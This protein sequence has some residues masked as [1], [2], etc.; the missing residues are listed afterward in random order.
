MV[1]EF[2]VVIASHRKLGDI[3]LP[4]NIERKKGQ[5]FFQ[6]IS[7]IT[8][9]DTKN[10]TFTEQQLNIIKTANEYSE[11]NIFKLFS[12]KKNLKDFFDTLDEA[13][14]T[15]QIRPY[16]EKR[17]C[18][19]I[20]FLLQSDIPVY[21]K[22]KNYQVV[23]EDERVELMT[24]PAQPVFNFVKSATEFLY[25]LSIR[26]NGKDIKLNKFP[27]T[28]I[29]QIP[30]SIIVNKKL[31]KVEN[32]DSK[33]LLPFF[34]K[35]HIT[36]PKAREKDYIETFVKN[37]VLNYPVKAVGIR[38]DEI[39]PQKTAIL[40]LEPDLSNNPVFGLKFKYGEHNFPYESTQHSAV[41]ITEEDT[42]C[43][44]TKVNRD[45]EWENSNIET[46]KQFNIT[47]KTGSSFNLTSLAPENET[48]EKWHEMVNWL[49]NNKERL[50]E[51]GF[52]VIKT[53]SDKEFYTGKIGLDFTVSTE[54]DWFDVHATVRIGEF[55]F[56]FIK[57][58]KHIIMGIREFTLPNNQVMVLPAEWFSKYREI[59][60]FGN[61][62]EESIKFK[63]HHFQIIK[64]AIGT[65]TG[66][67]I[68]EL[69][70]KLDGSA[71]DTFLIPHALHATLREYQKIGAHWLFQLYRNNLGGV[72][73]DDMGLGKTLQTIT[74]LL[75]V[76]DD[77]AEKQEVSKKKK[78]INQLNLFDIPAFAGTETIATSMIIMP[79]SLIH[80]WE[81]ELKKFAPSLNIYKLQGTQ[82]TKIVNELLEADVLLTSYGVVRNDI[83]LLK[84][85]N[86]K[87]VILDES[88][89]IK[90]PDS[91]IYK[92]VAQLQSDHKLVLTG[93]PIENS[94]T[95]LW[96]QLNFLNRDLLKSQHYFKEEFVV[97]IEKHN[98][99]LK[100]RKLQAII[101]PFILRRKKEEVLK[102]LPSLTEQTIYCE[103]TEEQNSLYEEEKSKIRNL[104]F[105]NIERKGFEK[106]AI[107]I[108][109]G[110]NRLRLMAN[111]PAMAFP[112][113][114]FDSG[115]F[116]EITRSIESIVEENHK[117]LIF[118]AYV[119]HLNLVANFIK[120]K[121]WEYSILTGATRNRSEV[122]ADFQH[123]TNNRIFLISLKAGGTGLNLTAA[124][125][126][127]IL[128]PWWNPAS[129][130]QA[131]SRAH[132]IGQDKKV[133]V[134]RFLTQ[135]SIEEKIHQLQQ[136][137][138]AMA[139]LFINS[140]NPFKAFSKDEIRNLFQ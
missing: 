108:L 3:I 101:R 79:V 48:S 85:I 2:V 98:D 122:I 118:S 60:V 78:N 117:V 32:I 96:A 116:E 49:N 67:Y 37:A 15:S 83:D 109:K 65:D 47:H 42:V 88:Q 90:N 72:L 124:D 12:K 131:I 52:D 7:L 99:E 35:E 97:P 23:H 126:V 33:K 86:F 36:V 19:C 50:I 76:K 89:T 82:R 44:F 95:D 22:E 11:K 40:S 62:E 4:Y 55:V 92:A 29:S 26:H 127:F 105:D 104:L 119:K 136:K 128:D 46:L 20:D 103:M 64:E 73:A 71:K 139:D 54:S 106:S 45:I 133:F 91:K 94:L 63:K 77:C 107:L 84:D 5:S 102:E 129:E 1:N 31:Y 53:K 56:P 132:R 59:F 13:S 43:V 74:L 57:F 87:Y 14:F 135:N 38:I 114:T 16:I 121:N 34:T 69:S 75:K 17:L 30:C 66:E 24:E 80:N 9:E 81:A 6:L 41:T 130:N 27:C 21:I 112:E 8:P 140:N 138:S 18:K 113:Y 125:Y 25:Y 110:L 58:R 61:D 120:E 68:K 111:H 39:T 10:Y 93:T 51:C 123:N 134:Y 137:K 70:D 115:K 100:Q 28:I